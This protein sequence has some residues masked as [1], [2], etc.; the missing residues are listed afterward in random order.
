MKLLT[1]CLLPRQRETKWKKPRGRLRQSEVFSPF[2]DYAI[3]AHHVVPLE[4]KKCMAS[5]R[6]VGRRPD[7][8]TFLCKFWHFQTA[9]S[10]WKLAW[11]T[12][13]LGIL[14]I[15]V[16]SFWL[17]E[18]II[19]NPIIYRLVPRPSR[20]EIRQWPSIW[21]AGSA[22]LVL[23]Q[24]QN[25]AGGKISGFERKAFTQQNFPES[26]VF[27]FKVL[28][29]DSGFKISRDMTKPGCFHFGFVVFVCKRQNQV[30]AKTFRIHHKSGTISS[31][32]N[33]VWVFM[34]RQFWFLLLL[35][36]PLTRV[37]W[38]QACTPVRSQPLC[39]SALVD[40]SL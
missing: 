9:V 7:C 14:W 21:I 23:A 8:H 28:T 2:A 24:T 31:S 40:A 25:I 34:V 29:L 30:G 22:I 33:L 15:S 12:P 32:V 19:A 5:G 1:S 6:R 35:S 38:T 18:S 20:F 4:K 39:L 11:L 36:R 3:V 10:Q 17:C 27:G 16:S 13:N 26:K 37:R